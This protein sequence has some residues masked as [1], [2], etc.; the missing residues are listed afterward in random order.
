MAPRIAPADASGLLPRLGRG[1]SLVL[2]RRN[3]PVARR[4]LFLISWPL[5]CGP[6]PLWPDRIFPARCARA[7]KIMPIL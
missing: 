4:D 1:G 3:G 2:R 6:V 5:L 7:G